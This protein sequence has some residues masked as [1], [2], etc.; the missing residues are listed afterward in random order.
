MIQISRTL[1][2]QLRSVIRRSIVE[3]ESRSEWPMLLCRSDGKTLCL[4]THGNGVGVLYRVST[5]QPANAIAFRSYVL[6][7]FEGR[8]GELL[9]LEQSAP[10]KGCAKW[11]D[12]PCPHVLEFET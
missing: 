4:Y 12:G 3:Q 8:K 6:K 7:E 5:E 2:R 9:T 1:A 10:G 11:H